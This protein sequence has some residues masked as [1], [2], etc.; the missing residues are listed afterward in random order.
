MANLMLN[1]VR[2]EEFC[3]MG[4]DESGGL[5]FFKKEDFKPSIDKEENKYIIHDYENSLLEQIS[6]NDYV[7]SLTAP[8][9]ISFFLTRKCNLNCDFCAT[10]QDK[11]SSELAYEDVIKTIDQL[12]QMNVF[13]V[14][15]T[16]GEPLKRDKIV[17]IA[18][19][20]ASKNIVTGIKSNG[21]LINDDLIKQFSDQI[22]FSLSIDGW[23]ETH[24]Q[25]RGKGTFAKLMD[26]IAILKRNNRAFGLHYT[27]TSKNYD[28]LDRVLDF[29]IENRIILTSDPVLNIGTAKSA[30]DILLTD[31]QIERYYEFKKEKRKRYR[32]LNNNRKA[33]QLNLYDTEILN[34]L[35]NSCEALKSTLHIDS[36]GDIY[37]CITSSSVGCGKVGNVLEAS[38]S[39]I[40]NSKEAD[41][42]RKIK[43]DQFT[44]CQTCEL[45]STCNFKC[46]ALS[47]DKN[48][49]L[50]GCGINYVSKRLYEMK[51]RDNIE[52]SNL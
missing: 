32:K 50:T 33:H 24:D 26:A 49:S 15:F 7:H 27:L 34:N 42:I 52:F 22:R 38:C 4:V 9:L 29:C 44:V 51:L 45:D 40:W 36:N 1:N 28:D 31:E 25:I 14:V 35:F 17:D 43:W 47:Y 46:M 16:G 19:Y 20:C 30:T 21:T 48:N 3:F 39:S 6:V 11:V 12:Y 37:P 10:E 41:E 5:Y 13:G 2:E 8:I 23:E 18:N